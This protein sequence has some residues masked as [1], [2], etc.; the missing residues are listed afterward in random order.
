MKVDNV[1]GKGTSCMDNFSSM[2]D[3]MIMELES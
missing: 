3:R 1:T 2:V